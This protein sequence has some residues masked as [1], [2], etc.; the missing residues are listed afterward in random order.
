MST[1]KPLQPAPLIAA[2]LIA[3]G[4]QR[5]IWM[6]AAIS[7]LIVAPVWFS[8][9]FE[10]LGPLQSF[11]GLILVLLLASASFS[12]LSRRKIYN[13]ATYTAFAWAIAI[14]SVPRFQSVGAIGLSNS[15]YGA[16]VC[17]A[18]MLIPYSL[19][20]GGAGDVKL[21][22]AIGALV[23][24]DSGLLVIAFA[25]ILA[26]IVIAGWSIWTKGPLRLLTA[27][28]R[29]FGSHWLPRYVFAPT[30]QQSVLLDQPIP[31]AGFFAIAVPLVVFDVPS[32][33][34]SI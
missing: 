2:P 28:L 24:I 11:S 33:L 27:L 5:L 15:L 23:G 7:P 8:L 10:L 25:Y 12:D 26:A 29:S 22:A 18:V 1:I 21:A 17:F 14:N 13:W 4:N 16:A 9:P 20:R 3:A 30:E 6:A 31:L 32:L 34:R 19:A